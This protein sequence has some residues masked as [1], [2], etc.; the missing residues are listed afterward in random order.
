LG[1]PLKIHLDCVKPSSSESWTHSNAFYRFNHVGS[2]FLKIPPPDP[3]I[4]LSK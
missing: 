4:F 1:V 3:T 2:A